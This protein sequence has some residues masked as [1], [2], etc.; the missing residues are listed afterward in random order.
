MRELAPPRW[1]GPCPH[2]PQAEFKSF[3]AVLKPLLPDLHLDISRQHFLRFEQR[4]VF[5][6]INECFNSVLFYVFPKPLILITPIL[7][8][9][10]SL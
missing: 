8:F 1:L 3:G 10:S 2:P 5:P 6:V 4:D 9:F 7:S